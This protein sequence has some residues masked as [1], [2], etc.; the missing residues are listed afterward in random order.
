VCPVRFFN[1]SHIFCEHFQPQDFPDVELPSVFSAKY[2]P[3]RTGDSFVAEINHNIPILVFL[4]IIVIYSGYNTAN[5]ICK[6]NSFK[7]MPFIIFSALFLEFI[8]LALYASIL[9]VSHLWDHGHNTMLFFFCQFDFS[10]MMYTLIF[11]LIIMGHGFDALTFILR[12]LFSMIY[13]PLAL[14]VVTLPY[15][16][17]QPF[18]VSRFIQVQVE[19]QGRECH[20]TTYFHQVCYRGTP[21]GRK[22]FIQVRGDDRVVIFTGPLCDTLQEA[23]RSADNIDFVYE[24]ADSDFIQLSNLLHD[25]TFL[26]HL[27]CLKNI[28]VV[29]CIFYNLYR[30]KAPL[31]CYVLQLTRE[32]ENFIKFGKYIV[33]IISQ[34]APNIERDVDDYYGADTKLW[35]PPPEWTRWTPL[36]CKPPDSDTP[37]AH[38]P[39]HVRVSPQAIE[40]E[41]INTRVF[42]SFAVLCA[43]V[44]SCST[45]P[46]LDPQM[47]FSRF[48]HVRS[49]LTDGPFTSGFELVKTLIR[50]LRVVMNEILNCCNSGSFMSLFFSQSD[51]WSL[52]S[53]V[54]TCFR[55]VHEYGDCEIPHLPIKTFAAFETSLTRLIS[56]AKRLSRDGSSQ[57]L[58][59]KAKLPELLEIEIT[60]RGNEFRNRMRRSPFCILF[61]GPSS[62]GK[63]TASELMYTLVGKYYGLDTAPGYKFVWNGSSKYYD[64]VRSDQW[65]MMIDDAAR[66]SG[67]MIS[68]ET[69]TTKPFIDVLNNVPFFPNMADVTEKGKI[70]FRPK[71]LLAT[72]NNKDLNA[73]ITHSCPSALARRVDWYVRV[74]PCNTFRTGA[75]LNAAAASEHI[76]AGREIGEIWRWTITKPVIVRNDANP[77][78]G[79]TVR[80]DAVRP[81]N[82][83]YSEMCEA[84][85]EALE[86]HDSIQSSVVQTVINLGKTHEY[87]KRCRRFGP[88]ECI[89][90]PPA[91]VVPQSFEHLKRCYRGLRHATIARVGEIRRSFCGAYVPMCD[92]ACSTCL[93]LGNCMRRAL[94]CLEFFFSRGLLY[95]LL[96]HLPTFACVALVSFVFLFE[97][98]LC[99]LFSLAISYQIMLLKQKILDVLVSMLFQVGQAH[100]LRISR[101]QFPVLSEV[102]RDL[103]V[104]RTR[105]Y[106]RW[107][108]F[109]LSLATTSYVL[110]SVLHTSIGRQGNILDTKS[111]DMPHKP[112]VGS[113][114]S[115]VFSPA[116]SSVSNASRS[117]PIS[118]ENAPQVARK[119]QK[120]VLVVEVEHASKFSRAHCL[121]VCNEF[122]IIN[123]H[124]LYDKSGQLGQKVTF[125]GTHNDDSSPLIRLGETV[126]EPKI[127]FQLADDLILVKT[128]SYLNRGKIVDLFANRDFCSISSGFRYTYAGDLSPGSLVSRFVTDIPSMQRYDSL[129]EAGVA[130]FSDNGPFWISRLSSTR[131]QPGMCGS[132]YVSVSARGTVILGL[133]VAGSSSTAIADVCAPVFRSELLDG[134]AALNDRTISVFS[135][136]F[137]Y[138]DVSIVTDAP[139]AVKDIKIKRL[140]THSILRSCTT[141][142]VR[143]LG[144]SS[145]RGTPRQSKVVKHPS[146]CFWH[147]HGVVSEKVAPV[148]DRRPWKVAL[149][150]FEKSQCLFSQSTMSRCANHFLSGIL[151]RLDAS[152]KDWKRQLGS[153]SIH[154]VS[155]GIDDMQYVDHINYH[156]SMGF[157]WYRPKSDFFSKGVVPDFMLDCVQ[158]IFDCYA[159]KTRA[160]PVFCGHLKDE[161]LSLEKAE[162]GKVRVFVGSPVD[163][164]LA[165]RMRFASFCGLY[166]HNRF[167][168]ESALSIAAQGQH[169][170]Q[171]YKYLTRDGAR[172]FGGDYKFYDK[173]MH[174]Y[175]TRLAF[176][177]VITI[178]EHSGRYSADELNDMR[179]MCEDTCN[180]VVEF[181][182]DFGMFF[183]GNPSGHPLTTII[184]CIAN[185][186]YIRYVYVTSGHD[187]DTFNENISLIT[188]GDDNLVGVRNIDTFNHTVV[189]KQLREI[190]IVYTMPDKRSDSTPFLEFDQIEFLGR[191]FVQDIINGT[192][193]MLAPLRMESIFKILCYSRSSDQTAY[194]L[195]C[196]SFITALNELAFHGQT[197][198]DHY[199]NLMQEYLEVNG[200]TM[201]L[202]NREHYLRIFFPELFPALECSYLSGTSTLP[203]IGYSLIAVDL[204]SAD[205]VALRPRSCAWVAMIAP[206]PA[207]KFFSFSTAADQKVS[208][209]TTLDETAKS[210][211]DQIGSLDTILNRKILIQSYA[212]TEGGTLNTSFR[213]W[214]LYLA[215]TNIAN[216]LRGFSKLRANLKL[217]FVI[218]AS[219]FHYG[220]FC[221]AYKPQVWENDDLSTAGTPSGLIRYEIR[222]Y[223]GGCI[224]NNTL[225]TNS[226]AKWSALMQRPH[227]MLYPQ[228]STQA[229]MI[230][231]FIH[232]NDTLHSISAGLDFAF[233]SGR[234]GKIDCFS[235]M[236]LTSASAPSVQ[237]VSI[238][239]FAELVHPELDGATLY[240]QALD[241][242]SE[243]RP[244]SS[245]ASAVAKAAG[246]LSTIPIIGPYAL[247]TSWA[248]ETVSRIAAWFGFTN[249]INI[250]PITPNRIV[251]ATRWADTEAHVPIAKLGLD[252][253][254]ELSID[255]SICGAP[256][257]DDM[258]ISSICAKPYTALV[259]NWTTA[260]NVGQKLI[261]GIVTPAHLQAAAF[262]PTGTEV[263]LT[264]VTGTETVDFSP[265]AW[266]AQCFNHWRGD[267]VVDFTILASKFHRGKLRFVYDPCGTYA[268]FAES[269]VLSRVFDIGEDKHFS[270]TI[271]YQGFRPYLNTLP[272]QNSLNPDLIIASRGNVN[273]AGS[274]DLST[275]AGAFTVQVMTE[276]S[277]PL[278]KDVSIITRIR[279]KNIE[280]MSPRNPYQYT[281]LNF[282]A[283]TL[284]IWNLPPI[285]VQRQGLET[286]SDAAQVPVGLSEDNKLALVCGGETCKSLRQL[287]HRW[288]QHQVHTLSSTGYGNGVDYYAF[289]IKRFPSFPGRASDGRSVVNTSIPYT[290]G[291]GTFL[292][293]IVPAFVGWRGGIMHRVNPT[294]FSAPGLTGAVVPMKVDCSGIAR[295][296]ETFSIAAYGISPST[297]S[298]VSA[299]AN[300]ISHVP[301][302]GLLNNGAE[303]SLDPIQ[304]LEVVAPDYQ[305]TR[306]RSAN[307]FILSALNNNIPGGYGTTWEISDYTEMFIDNLMVV[308]RTMINGIVPGGTY[309]PATRIVHESYA[310]GASDINAFMFL[311]VP[312]FYCSGTNPTP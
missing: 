136:G 27:C 170:L 64:G 179:G 1:G 194:D 263:V 115:N 145:Y 129:H 254:N 215:N 87:C 288:G 144:S 8:V 207:A 23:L 218:N 312:S 150:E 208:I 223:S 7:L 36:S 304:S 178:C 77:V 73:H 220:A 44:Y 301:A 97:S 210:T 137:S 6:R 285:T 307:Q 216:K 18:F 85:V 88:H 229:E 67:P 75:Q 84:L 161:P 227:V 253:R 219:P 63:S 222:D 157:P 114:W 55:H 149:E 47:L 185:C 250:G 69:N 93:F 49:Q 305:P 264:G 184:N 125:F 134:I 154:E 167:I 294:P 103:V 108:L 291:S 159:Q 118:T 15:L 40:L 60:I 233:T 255:N 117:A 201:K 143:P 9:F 53:D 276:L 111:E 193:V 135:Q 65:C 153:L 310:A 290:Y 109:V 62:I 58:A 35:E 226:I 265:A 200:I 32:A 237:S 221:F 173:G 176:H 270:V 2:S 260:D 209:D 269:F 158:R 141:G 213:P 228:E 191:G 24:Q 116:V 306:F 262:V 256:R 41:S 156:T 140:H 224:D 105:N 268:N 28:V 292:N 133:H 247:A 251:K 26:D 293:W 147:A 5:I 126:L 33:P 74:E 113:W 199:R 280:F 50:A 190:G 127:L 128:T 205:S 309:S 165:V 286:E 70:D 168:F 78:R 124:I 82:C 22:F 261:T 94:Y 311:N 81:A 95:S 139:R 104:L 166:Q 271:P 71:L 72:T 30:I 162:K 232:T 4:W 192:E 130:G 204:Q 31:S 106:V 92:I 274:V 80:F 252:P 236:P 284:N 112:K 119:V 86:R 174:E 29:T 107:M 277:G 300:N 181:N 298:S 238:D 239:V 131:G 45:L 272:Y 102:A 68:P 186:L 295:T 66:E 257:S 98:R 142:L 303:L 241:E 177:I 25:G 212:I 164:T 100:I 289:L 273:T 57:S 308:Y 266:I 89:P 152:C 121:A 151:T 175:I 96:P 195:L 39:E 38:L 242:Y 132:P 282:T 160:F 183:V 234:L 206:L 123:K 240:R 197:I 120:N 297:G 245:T 169:W 267:M 14:L 246:A 278:D 83:T 296:R 148:F 59:I 101:C 17:F 37:P 279:W 275:F 231:P 10:P 90:S 299:L 302:S 249:T 91:V 230:V 217:T 43:F 182:G 34:L 3:R 42:S 146:Y 13:Y 172:V 189:E 187:L 46:N 155:N 20:R 51:F 122:A 248:A 16:I 12:D 243:Q 61:Y 110:L 198:F 11:Y 180:P 235:L 188:Y 48:Y 203:E 287:C 258:I 99:L 225:S 283:T 202:H 171:L 211:D 214:R 244:I 196:M 19:S 259:S 21:D 163:F 76:N 56:D 281:N 54:I 52:Y 138:D 79:D